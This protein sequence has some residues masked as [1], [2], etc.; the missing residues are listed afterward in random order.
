MTPFDHAALGEDRRSLGFVG[1]QAVNQQL[2]RVERFQAATV[3]P[4]REDLANDP[5]PF[6]SGGAPRLV[7][8][9]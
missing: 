3:Q 5:V 1:D 4:E 6:R 9:G 2:D 7:A 8:Q